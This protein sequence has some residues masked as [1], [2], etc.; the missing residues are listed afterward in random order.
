M[1]NH[2]GYLSV[3]STPGLG[4]TVFIG[5]PAMP[6]GDAPRERIVHAPSGRGRILVLEDEPAVGDIACN[7][8]NFLGHDVD[9]VHDAH[10]A[11]EHYKDAL[12]SARPFDA[13]MLDLVVPGGI[14][15]RETLSLL[16]DVDPGVKAIVVSGYTRDAALAGADAGPVR[17]FIAKPFTLDELDSTL[18]S[19]PILREMASA[20][21]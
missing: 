18:S 8:L 9:V 21:M 19:V 7:M 17:A 11:V 16:T 12:A 1:K 3:T 15:G 4:S 20:L 13:V 6:A 2:G 5:L 14:G 10:T